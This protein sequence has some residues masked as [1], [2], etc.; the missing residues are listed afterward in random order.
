MN[1][2]AERLLLLLLVEVYSVHWFPV[3]RGRAL[4]EGSQD[5]SEMI[6]EKN[7]FKVLKQNVFSLFCD[8]VW[9]LDF[10]NLTTSGL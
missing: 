4:A 6:K 7:T 9:I 8:T 2:G 10:D 1:S 5:K 3:C